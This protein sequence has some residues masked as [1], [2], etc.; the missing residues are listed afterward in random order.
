MSD[1][2]EAD[3]YDVLKEAGVNAIRLRVWV[4]SSKVLIKPNVVIKKA[5]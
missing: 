3:C 4:D 2:T 1:G 5:W